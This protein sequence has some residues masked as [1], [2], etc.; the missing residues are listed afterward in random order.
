MHARTALRGTLAFAAALLL[1]TAAQAQLFR[2]YL[3]IN[4]S[5][6]NPCTL[7][8]PCRLLPAAL[9]AVAS[10][11]EIWMLDSA[12]Y[13]TA[14]VNVTKSVTILAVPGVVGS[15]VATGGPAINIATPAVRVTLRNLVLV[16]LPG[17]GGTRGVQ[18][19]A[20]IGL[21]VEGS[22][23]ANMPAE[24]ILV[25]GNA[26]VRITDSVI[27]DSGTIGVHLEDGPQATINR[28]TIA[29][30]GGSG[31]YVSGNTA[32]TLTTAEVADSTL[33]G[34]YSHVFVSTVQEGAAVRATVRESRL[35]RS[36][37]ALSVQSAGAAADLAVSS[38][39]ISGSVYGIYASG[40]GV[41]V[42]AGGNAVTH[43]TW[44]F[45]NADAGP[46]FESAG[47][48]V[49]RHN[50]TNTFGTITPAGTI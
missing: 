15:V 22:V 29:N 1:S 10:G 7:P 40:A 28:S 30:S 5:D 24:G 44:G 12:N 37:I 23:I 49:V 16:P 26:H 19:T 18:M 11:G 3:A 45:Y 47:S 38:C 35:S 48:N 13:N 39:Q 33:V 20:G 17:A 50:T 8:Q 9:N 6:T 34:N 46:L 14:T 31:V 21:A 32:S 42:I 36:T 43:N 41:R 27:R 4:G 25:F 2:A